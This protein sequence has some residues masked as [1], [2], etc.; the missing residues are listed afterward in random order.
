M[1]APAVRGV[2]ESMNGARLVHDR[3]E[4][5][6]REVLI[7]D[8]TKGQGP[9]AF[10]P[11]DRQDRRARPRHAIR[12]R[13]GAGD[14]AGPAVAGVA[15]EQRGKGERSA[16]ARADNFK[17][18]RAL[19]GDDTR[20][21]CEASEL[22]VRGWDGPRDLRPEIAA[23]V[24]ELEATRWTGRPGS[25]IRSMVGMALATSVYAVPTWT[26][27]VALVSEQAALRAVI[28]SCTPRRHPSTP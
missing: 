4:E 26:R 28:T 13:P 12:T 9:G 20:D 24:S 21:Q 17:Q 3:L 1:W 25:P 22:E 8:A 14:L 2:I 5:H 11:Q 15:E 16:S 23:L 18:I 6:G 10:G 27:L 19:G 7:A